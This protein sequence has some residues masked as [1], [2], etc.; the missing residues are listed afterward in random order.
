M[1]EKIIRI[2]KNWSKKLDSLLP[3]F[4]FDKTNIK[5]YIQLFYQQNRLVLSTEQLYYL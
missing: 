2:K 1:I 4:L 3:T 5:A